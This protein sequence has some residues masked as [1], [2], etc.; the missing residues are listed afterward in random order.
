MNANGDSSKQIWLTE[1]GC[2]TGT[3]GG[4]PAD[5]TDATLAQQITDAFSSARTEGGIGPLLVYSWQDD[6]T[7]NDGDFGLYNSNATPKPDSLAAYTK[8]ADSN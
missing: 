1:F 7:D 8:A 5:C 2:P 3:A 6:P 4:Y